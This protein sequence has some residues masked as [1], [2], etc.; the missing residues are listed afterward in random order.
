MEVS[1]CRSKKG[2]AGSLPSPGR[3]NT[4]RLS[5]CHSHPPL[6]CDKEDVQIPDLRKMW[7]PLTETNSVCWDLS[8]NLI[9]PLE[10]RRQLWAALQS[11]TAQWLPQPSQNLSWNKVNSCKWSVK[12]GN[13]DMLSR[14]CWSEGIGDLTSPN[15]LRSKAVRIS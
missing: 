15:E 8:A 13:E 9:W 3:G 14:E 2:C 10:T 4:P 11:S 6:Y 12:E 1:T 7:T 5:G